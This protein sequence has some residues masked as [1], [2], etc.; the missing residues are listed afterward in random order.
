MIIADTQGRITW[1]NAA[2][3][4]ML[5]YAEGELVGLPIVAVIPDRVKSDPCR[6]LE[7]L[8]ANGVSTVREGPVEVPALQ[9]DGTELPV[10]LTTGLWR[11]EDHLLVSATIRDISERKRAEEALR[12]SEEKYRLLFE[13]SRDAIMAASPPSWHFTSGNPAAIERFGALDEADFLSRAP[14]ELSP[15]LQPGGRPSAEMAREMI[16]TA[17]R[18]GSHYFEWRHRR[19]DGKEFPATVLLTRFELDGVT[20]VQATVRDVS[21]ERL[22]EAELRQAQKM[23]SIGQLAGGIAHDFNNILTGINGYT[24]EVL[25]ALPEDDHRADDLRRVLDLSKRAATLTAQLLKFSRRGQPRRTATS[26][27]ELTADTARLLT[28]MVGTGIQVALTQDADLWACHADENELQQAIVNLSVN[29]RDAMPGGGTLTL[30]TAN[31]TLTEARLMAHRRLAAGS[32]VTVTITDTGTGMDEATQRRMFEPFFTTKPPGEGTGLGLSTVLG[33]V[34]EHEGAIDV[35][36]RPGAG[37]SFTIWLPRWEEPAQD[38]GRGDATHER[39][40]SGTVSL[41]NI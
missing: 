5:G 38:D 33:V 24:V 36:S 28:R 30:T 39:G 21:R 12:R 11:S 15:P 18:E 41:A 25:E 19:V 4:T 37:A 22:M 17:L 23:G 9:K 27:N 8:V 3:H 6:A 20:Q 32:Y 13:S 2:A 40:G 26:M 7:A 14:W 10:E 1:N 34:E 31:E 35:R 29:A 16:E